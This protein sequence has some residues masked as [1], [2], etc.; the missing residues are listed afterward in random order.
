MSMAVIWRPVPAVPVGKSLRARRSSA[1]AG[2]FLA[3]SPWKITCLTQ[4][5][6]CGIE[7]VPGDQRAVGRARLDLMGVDPLAADEL[8]GLAVAVDV[9]PEQGVHRGDRVVDHAL[10]PGALAARALAL[11]HP[12]EAVVVAHAVDEVGEA[13]AIDVA[14]QDLDAGRAQVPVGVPG[15]GLVGRGRRGPRTSPWA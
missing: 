2:A 3:G 1:F 11:F 12:E 5:F 6:D 10:G 7:V 8:V 14:G 15:P 9:G 13:V 4:P